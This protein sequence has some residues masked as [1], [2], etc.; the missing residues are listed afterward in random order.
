M[1]SLSGLDAAAAAA[2]A[3]LHLSEVVHYVLHQTAQCHIETTQHVG[4]P[5]L[6][7]GGHDCRK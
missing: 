7:E 3:A 6:S 5:T 1:F 4:R 2:A